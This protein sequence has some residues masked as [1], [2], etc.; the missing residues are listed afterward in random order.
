MYPVSTG[1]TPWDGSL[2][3]PT[4]LSIIILR[5]RSALQS[6]RSIWTDQHS[7]GIN[8]CIEMTSS[9][10]GPPFCKHSRLASCQ[11]ITMIPK[12]PCL[13]SLIPAPLMNIYMSLNA[14]LIGLS[15]FPRLVYLVVSSP[16]W[17][18]NYTRRFRHSSQFLFLRPFPSPSCRK[19]NLMTGDILSALV[20]H[21]HNP[22]PSP[23]YHPTQP[24]PSP[25]PHHLRCPHLCRNPPLP[26]A[27]T[28]AASPRRR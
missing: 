14:W 7:A 27:T 9:R 15:G 26:S 11:R 12:V 4:S 25:T 2:G 21:L 13:S 22:P 5:M 17:R 19:T 6:P 20:T 24:L 10:H 3:S 16:A 28:Y 23:L 8:G 18:R 1:P